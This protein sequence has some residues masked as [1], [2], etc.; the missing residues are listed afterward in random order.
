MIYEDILITNLRV[1][2]KVGYN[3]EGQ[4]IQVSTVENF[5]IGKQN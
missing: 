5:A 1:R 3:G 4:I 2:S